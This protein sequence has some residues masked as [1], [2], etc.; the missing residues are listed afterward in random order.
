MSLLCDVCNKQYSSKQTLYEH[1]KN[2]HYIKTNINE[3]TCKFCSKELSNN[4]SCKRH[5]KKCTFNKYNNNEKIKEYNKKEKS[6]PKKINNAKLIND[7]NTK[8]NTNNE[9]IKKYFTIAGEI[10][11]KVLESDDIDNLLNININSILEIIKLYNF[12]EKYP[13]NHTYCTMAL[14]SKYLSKINADTLKIESETKKRFFENLLISSMNSINNIYNNYIIKNPNK[15][16]EYQEKLTNIHNFFNDSL[17]KK[18][19]AKSF[20]IEANKISYNNRHMV[21]STWNKI[22]NQSMQEMPFH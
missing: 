19:N 11:H 3:K 5:E 1:R 20:F 17:F 9:I 18:A 16:K 4:Q 6:D 2:V 7:I 22:I 8:N 12:N 21:K 14:N 13:K 15:K 10:N